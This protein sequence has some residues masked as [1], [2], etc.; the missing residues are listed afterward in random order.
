MKTVYFI[1][2][3]ALVILAVQF[4]DKNDKNEPGKNDGKYAIVIHGG[5][6]FMNKEIPESTKQLY[7]NSLET[8]LNIGKNILENGGSSLDAVESAV[9]FL[10]DD[11]LFNAGRGA[12]FTSAGTHELD[13]SIMYGADL[14]CGAV[15]GVKHIKNPISLARLVKEKTKHVLLSGDGAEEFA[16]QM[17][18]EMVNQNY[19]YT[20]SSYESLK[21]FEEK[22]KQ[23][24]VGCVALD[25]N[26][27]LS[28]ATSTGGMTGKMPGRIGDSPLVNAG[29]YA[30]NKT[31]AVSCTGTGELFIK[32]T[33]AYNVS[34]LMEMKNMTLQHAA[35]EMINK[36]LEKGTGGLIAVDKD[37]N[38]VMLYNTGSMLRA[39][40]DS[41]GKKEIKIWE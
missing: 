31:C 37:G 16:K 35:E 26:G 2:I 24:T 1:I 19:F 6:G 8:A 27:N 3:T 29:T 14:S 13:A 15:T 32:N 34:A 20:E 10:E 40:L 38:V 30:S 4:I 39:S 7:M 12:V 36:R 11:S 22:N 17:N 5:A 41:K 28:A 23:G 9:K 21:R 18:V 25:K 33:V